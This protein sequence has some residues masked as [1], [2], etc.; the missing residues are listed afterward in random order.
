MLFGDVGFDDDEDMDTLDQIRDWSR[1]DTKIKSKAKNL[2]SSKKSGA[3]STS[4][5]QEE[6]R[7]GCIAALRQL[8]KEGRIS[9]KQ[10]R[11]LLTDI[12]SCSAK[13]E[14]SMVEVAY[15]LLY[16]TAS[17]ANIDENKQ[18]TDDAE[19]EFA[20]Q[21]IVFAQTFSDYSL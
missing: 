10:K 17:D 14:V 3:S 5:A 12:I 13:G 6:R 4:P 1:K 21:C 11:S 2:V 8:A 16:C 9:A 18:A 20:D 19:E 15:E 7:Q